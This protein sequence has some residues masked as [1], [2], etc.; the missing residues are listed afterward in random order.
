MKASVRTHDERY[1]RFLATQ[2]QRRKRA[3][4][5]AKADAAALKTLRLAAARAFKELNDR[6]PLA[7]R[8]TKRPPSKAY[9]VM[10][11]QMAT[12]SRRRNR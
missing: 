8:K 3:A 4:K 11:R 9:R 6:P 1:A 2:I 10:R 12:A 7:R 5:H